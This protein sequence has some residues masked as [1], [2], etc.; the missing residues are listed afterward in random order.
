MSRPELEK[1]AADLDQAALT[2][3]AIA[4]QGAD[5]GLDVDDAYAVQ[6][7]LIDRRTS[8]GER[9]LGPKLGFTSYAKMAQM[10]VS[11][12]IV[13]QLTTTMRIDDG[14]AVDLAELIHPRIEP[15]VAFRLSCD[16][17]P[18]D[19]A[20]NIEACV[21]AMAP[22]LE[23]IDSRY[24]DFRFSLADVVADNTSAARFVLGPWIPFDS[25]IGNRGV[26]LEVDG[27]I[28]E[29]GSTAAILGHPVRALHA[30]VA[31]AARYGVGL[32]AGAIVLAGAATA[33]TPVSHPATIQAHVSGL[34]RVS[35]QVESSGSNG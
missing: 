18:H 32:P 12:I 5:L 1:L 7:L 31:I 25:D 17:D 10:G 23:V 6:Q 14:G 4:Q 2:A 21:D 33:A 22:A 30:L 9:Y 15:E 26:L 8:R 16:V 20:V 13:G 27:A 29:T 24:R 19:P 34:G 35:V 28:V 11:E 3:T